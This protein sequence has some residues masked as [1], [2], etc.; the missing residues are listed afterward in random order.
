[1][2]REIFDGPSLMK[3]DPA[4]S[5]YHLLDPPILLEFDLLSSRRSV[6]C[7]PY[8]QTSSPAHST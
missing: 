2:R 1:M 6:D 8:R 5:V 7:P 4:K 3:V